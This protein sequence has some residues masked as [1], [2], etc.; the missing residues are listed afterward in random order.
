MRI[1]ANFCIHTEPKW[2][3]TSCSWALLQQ[4]CCCSPSSAPPCLCSH[5]PHPAI[6]LPLN[7]FHNLALLPY[8][9]P[10]AFSLQL[11]PLLSHALIQFPLH[12]VVIST[13][14]IFLFNVKGSSGILPL[15]CTNLVLV[16]R[17]GVKSCPR[18]LLDF[19]CCTL[20]FRRIEMS[21]LFSDSSPFV[22]MNVWSVEGLFYHNPFFTS[23]YLPTFGAF[24]VFP[25][26]CRSWHSIFPFLCIGE[27]LIVL[28]LFYLV[29]IYTQYIVNVKV[30]LFR[31]SSLHYASARSSFEECLLKSLICFCFPQLQSFHFCRHNHHHFPHLAYTSP[32][33]PSILWLPGEEY[34][35]IWERGCVYYI[36]VHEVALSDGI[37]KT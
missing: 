14:S 20:V 37:L 1:Y 28:L 3:R 10:F 12:G 31:R 16:N 29:Y 4:L 33:E 11:S 36:A 17:S 26:P 5:L 34:V 6:L 13:R 32:L 25:T 9:L 23:L 7:H 19:Q 18:F 22:K 24:S 15:C 30:I 35:L 27:I 8:F 2:A 21:W